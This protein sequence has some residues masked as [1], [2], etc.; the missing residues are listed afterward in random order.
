M[1][2]ARSSFQSAPPPPNVSML[3]P[4]GVALQSVFDSTTA[5]NIEIVNR[6]DRL[7]DDVLRMALAALN[8]EEDVTKVA[9]EASVRAGIELVEIE[10]VTIRSAIAALPP[11]HPNASLLR[12]RMEIN[13]A[14]VVY[15]NAS[16]NAGDGTYDLKADARRLAAIAS[17]VRRNAELSRAEASQF[18][19]GFARAEGI[20]E[21]MRSSIQAAFATFGDSAAVVLLIADDLDAMASALSVDTPD[22]GA[23]DALIDSIVQ[24]SETLVRQ[25][26]A[27]A[28]LLAN[29]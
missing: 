23:A 21:T 29:R 22:F 8:G 12:S 26:G 4:Q 1:E 6:L 13:N 20:T 16:R 14:V 2:R 18:M 3:G 25:D 28:A 9:A 19:V 24:H 27:R 17:E 10:N 15:M 11:S 5:N 7:G